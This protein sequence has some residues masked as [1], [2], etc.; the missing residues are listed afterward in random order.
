MNG[1]VNGNANVTI[2]NAY[3][4]AD[5][6][7]DQQASGTVYSGYNANQAR[8]EGYFSAFGFSSH[9]YNMKYDVYGRL[10]YNDYSNYMPGS[11][12]WAAENCSKTVNTMLW[13]SGDQFLGL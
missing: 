7:V 4:N 3:D 6:L 13:T 9:Q 8:Y 1:W 10:V 5:R 12:P 11:P 2:T